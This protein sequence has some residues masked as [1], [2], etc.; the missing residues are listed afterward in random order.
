MKDKERRL[1]KDF[2]RV[3]HLKALAGKKNWF[4]ARVGR[5]RI[6]FTVDG[7]KAEIQRITKKD[8]Q[9]YRNLIRFYDNLKRE[10]DIGSY[11]AYG[12]RTN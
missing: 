4:R 1:Q 7:G 8:D 3:P 2:R 12:R 9:T 11:V 6:I 5:Y 10:W